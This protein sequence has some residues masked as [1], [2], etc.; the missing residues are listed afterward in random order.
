M[1]QA[2]FTSSPVKRGVLAGHLGCSF[3]LLGSGL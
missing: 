3:T 1:R 2:G